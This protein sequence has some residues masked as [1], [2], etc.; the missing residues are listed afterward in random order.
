VAH[1]DAQLAAGYLHARNEV[2]EIPAGTF[3]GL[4]LQTRPTGRSTSG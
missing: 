1:A 4:P 3:D 2:F